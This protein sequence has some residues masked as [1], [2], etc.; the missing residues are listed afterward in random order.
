MTNTCLQTQVKAWLMFAY[1][2]GYKVDQYLPVN[3]SIN[4]VNVYLLSGKTDFNIKLPKKDWYA[5]IQ[6]TNPHNKK[7]NEGKILKY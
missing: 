3:S 7:K 2:L 1:Y 6:E 4:P 5:E